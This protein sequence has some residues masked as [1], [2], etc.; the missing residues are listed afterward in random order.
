[1]IGGGVVDTERLRQL[2]AIAR[3]GTMSA[4]AEVLHISQPALSRSLA[5]LEADLGVALFDRPGR[6]LVLNE[7]GA[8]VL[9]HARG[10]LRS[11]EAMRRAIDDLGRGARA[12]A[13]GS[14]APAPLWLLTSLMVGH[15]PERVLTSRIVEDEDICSEVLS[16]SLDLAVTHLPVDQPEL[17]CLP[18][19][20]ESLSV[21]LPPDHRLAGREVV[22]ASELDGETFLLLAGIGFWRGVCERVLPR[23]R[24]LVQEDRVVLDQLLRTSHL[25]YFV[26]DA[27]GAV[28]GVLHAPERV[29][30]PIRDASVRVTFYLLCRQDARHE[31]SEVVDW[32][33]SQVHL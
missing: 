17:R 30:V 28:P 24:F 3:H 27:P 25:P 22:S 2:D 5:R 14:V 8:L 4:A 13:V 20:T 32:V 10:I 26:T 29:V 21:C 9:E 23:S 12:V 18:L 6:R 19:M 15:F 31:V 7:A 16:G 11:E 1:M 33:R